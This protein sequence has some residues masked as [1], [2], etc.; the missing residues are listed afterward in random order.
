MDAQH[1]RFRVEGRGIFLTDGGLETTLVFHEGIDLPFFASFPLLDRPEGRAVLEEYFDRYLAIAE[2]AGVGFLVD[3]PTWRA[4]PD[5]G[6]KLGYG[7]ADLARIHRD[8]V[9]FARAAAARRPAVRT[10]V[11]GV[12]GPRGDGYRADR[13]MT[14]EEAEAYHGPQ[15]RAFA[16]AGADLAAAITMTNVP[17]AVGVARA[18]RAA[19][20]PVVVAV[21][22][23]TDGRLPSGAALGE[24][25]EAID[26]ATG[27][28]PMFFMV[29]CAHPTHF[30]GVLSGAWTERI[31]G[32]RANAS[33]RS[34]A[35]LDEATDLDDGD[36][37]DL[38]RRYAEL[39]RLLPRATVF[40]GCC[41][42]DHRHVEAI[43]DHVHPGPAR[44]AA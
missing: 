7:P 39:R 32:V 41:G 25:V 20:I 44:R 3:T 12:V 14:G 36:P 8:G 5:W 40:G 22:V 34:H 23:E 42:T 17:E 2:R 21:T 35:E 30:E 6:A 28:Y 38:A 33:V 10:M 19:G 24:A 4:N 43:C 26:A 11:S 27:G 13:A 15:V 37:L 18:A 16:D 9:A 29:N 1:D 31:G